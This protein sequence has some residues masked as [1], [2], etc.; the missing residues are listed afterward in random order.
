MQLTVD[1]EENSEFD[2]NFTIDFNGFFVIKAYKLYKI[3]NFVLRNTDKLD[4]FELSLGE[5]S[6]TKWIKFTVNDV[7]I[8]TEISAD[9]ES[10]SDN[11]SESEIFVDEEEDFEQDDGVIQ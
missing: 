1:E 10:S 5:S 6:G 9:F 4:E 7:I 8:L 3:L 11:D 2:A